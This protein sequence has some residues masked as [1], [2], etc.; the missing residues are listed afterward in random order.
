MVL[1]HEKSHS[2]TNIQRIF[3]SW[4]VESINAIFNDEYEGNGMVGTYDTSYLHIVN[5]AKAL[6][7]IIGALPLQKYHGYTDEDPIIEAL[8]EI[9]DDEDKAYKLLTN[10]EEYKNMIEK[11][12]VDVMT[13][14]EKQVLFSLKETIYQSFD[15][16]YYAKKGIHITDDLVMLYYL[17]ISSFNRIMSNRATE[18]IPNYMSEKYYSKNI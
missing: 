8:M 14:E 12:S 15:E 11:I 13:Y 10:I 18:K 16:Y 4:L 3:L 7:E 17:D 2:L 5:Y 9:I 1:A 6:M